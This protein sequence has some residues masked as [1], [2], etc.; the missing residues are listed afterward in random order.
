MQKWQHHME[1]ITAWTQPDNQERSAIYKKV[2]EL[3]ERGWEMVG[4]AV[5]RGD[6]WAAFKKPIEEEEQEDRLKSAAD[7]VR[8]GVRG[9]APG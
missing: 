3:G 5:V 4:I 7:A 1:M 2:R 8:R 6:L 9:A